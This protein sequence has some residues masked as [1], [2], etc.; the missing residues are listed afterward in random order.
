MV[1]LLLLDDSTDPLPA[2][3]FRALWNA[4]NTI[5]TLGDLDSLNHAQKGS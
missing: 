4:A 1:G 3:L 5:S 2:Q